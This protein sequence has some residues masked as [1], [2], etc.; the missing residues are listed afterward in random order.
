LHSIFYP[1]KGFNE[2]C[3]HIFLFA[4]KKARMAAVIFHAQG[5]F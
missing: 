4:E 3:Q 1:K 5:L 2:A